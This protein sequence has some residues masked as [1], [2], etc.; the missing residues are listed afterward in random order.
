MELCARHKTVNFLFDR[1]YAIKMVSALNTIPSQTNAVTGQHYGLSPFNYLEIGMDCTALLQMAEYPPVNLNLGRKAAIR[2]G[3]RVIAVYKEE[4]E[5]RTNSIMH[6]HDAESMER[7]NKRQCKITALASASA[8][9]AASASASASAAVSLA[10]EA[11]SEAT[12]ALASATAPN[13]ILLW[14]AAQ[15]RVIHKSTQELH[16]RGDSF[17]VQ[18]N[19]TRLQDFATFKSLVN[20]YL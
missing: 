18:S 7:S 15:E 20:Q 2:A 4:A 16:K 11:V 1:R 19:M 8:S 13:Q 10:A 14:I 6:D 3:K 17:S 12:S 5:S 9:A